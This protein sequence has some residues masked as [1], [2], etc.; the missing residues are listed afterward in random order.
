MGKFITKA[1]DLVPTVIDGRNDMLVKKEKWEKFNSS[2]LGLG[3]VGA[4]SEVT[5]AIAAVF[6]LEGFTQFCKQIDPHLAVPVFLEHF[7]NWFF[8][9]IKEETKHKEQENGIATYHDLPI[10]TKFL[11]DGILVIWDTK[12]MPPIA[13]ANIITSCSQICAKYLKE[14]YPKIKSK[15]T[16]A[17]KR[18][19]CGV[20]KGNIFSVGNGEDYVGPCINF[21]S[22]LQKLPGL[23]FAFSDRGF[24][25]EEN[26]AEQDLPKWVVK[27]VQIRGIGESELVYIRKH[28]YTALSAEDAKFY[29]EP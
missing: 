2:I 13:Q 12:N 17:P 22:R 7:L 9:K 3:D 15:V 20:A 24:K 23:L 29:L 8:E 25:V 14:F 10:L 21:A 27:K 26:W 16:D 1:S 6:D 5:A 4:K 18:I 11:G 19:R 28:E